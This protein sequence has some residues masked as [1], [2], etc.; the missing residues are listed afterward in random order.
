MPRP[1]AAST[2]KAFRAIAK[3]YDHI[4]DVFQSGDGEQLHREFEAGRAVW[5]SVSISA[6][7]SIPIYFNNQ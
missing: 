4:V 1:I 3:P 5:K 7:P 6:N 2:E